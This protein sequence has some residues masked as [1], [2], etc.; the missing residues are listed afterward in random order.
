[1]VIIIVRNSIAKR[2]EI[3]NQG[4]SVIGYQLT[5]VSELEYCKTGHSAF[6]VVCNAG[7]ILL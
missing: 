4:L 7:A 6:T 5:G 2:E 3:H 1:M